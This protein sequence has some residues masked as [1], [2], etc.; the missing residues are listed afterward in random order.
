MKIGIIQASSQSEKNDLIYR[1]AQKHNK[2]AEIINFGCFPNDKTSYSY[3]EISILAGLL[4]NS[5]SVDLIITG[6]SSGQ[7]M[8]LALNSIPGV[9]CGYVPTPKDAFLFARINNGNAVS[10]PL[11]EDYTWAGEENMEETIKTILTEPFG[12]GYPESEAA[13]KLK[14]TEL[15][16]KIRKESQKTI[17]E[18]FDSLDKDLR[19]KL[20]SKKDV[21]DY[22][23]KHNRNDQIA[24]ILNNE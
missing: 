24:E 18:T 14:D 12:I 1:A 10:L 7:G 22:I 15:L 21:I 9:L 23:E 17:K 8:M 19:E 2:N 5:G 20:L 6:C 16:K 3:I 4:L 13:R 11:G